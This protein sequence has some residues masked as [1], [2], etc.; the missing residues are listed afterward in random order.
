MRRY[1]EFAASILTLNQGYDDA[2]LTHSLNRLRNEVEGLLYRMSGEI[3]DRKNRLV[4][5]INNYDLVLTIL[6]E[7]N[8]VTFEAEKRYFNSLLDNKTAEYVEEELKPYFGNLIAFVNQVE[9]LGGGELKSVDAARF[10][11][12]AT[13]F[14]TA[15]KPSLNSI[16]A[17]VI[18]S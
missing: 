12:L 10:E 9:L 5:L 16:N 14:N 7:H 18:Q 4:F 2:L 8:I 1:A 3:P 15:W 13:D 17:S 6:G 11:K